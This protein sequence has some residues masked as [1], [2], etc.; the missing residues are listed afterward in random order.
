[1][2]KLFTFILCSVITHLLYSQ[3]YEDCAWIQCQYCK[4]KILKK[5][6]VWNQ[7]CPNRNGDHKWIH[8]GAYDAECNAQS[9][10]SEKEFEAKKEKVKNGQTVISWHTNGKAKL[11][12]S[13]N[14]YY[15]YSDIGVLIEKLENGILSIIENG[16][17]LTG[18]GILKEDWTGLPYFAKDGEWIEDGYK[19]IYKDGR[20]EYDEKDLKEKAEKAKYES[21]LLEIKDCQSLECFQMLKN[22]YPDHTGNNHFKDAE[23]RT[24]LNDI[25]SN[26]SIE[27][28]EKYEKLEATEEYSVKIKN[29]D[30]SLK[31]S[32]M[33]EGNY[34]FNLHS[35]TPYEK[36]VRATLL[37][38]ISQ[39]N[40]PLN[41]NSL[42]GELQYRIILN[43]EKSKITI[44]AGNS[45]LIWYQKD[46]FSTLKD[47][48]GK[49]F[50]LYEG[51]KQICS[52][53]YNDNTSQREIYLDWKTITEL[54][55]DEDIL[56]F[57]RKSQYVNSYFSI[58]FFLGSQLPLLKLKNVEY[59]KF[60][61]NR[62][63]AILLSALKR[64]E[65]D[66][67]N[68][69]FVALKLGYLYWQMEDFD[70]S[71]KYFKM[72]K[73]ENL[74]IEFQKYDRAP[75]YNEPVIAI[76]NLNKW[77]KDVHMVNFTNN[78]IKLPNEEEMIKRIKNL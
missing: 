6:Y 14:N 71:L 40:V 60:L 32:P 73:D 9:L 2:K 30:K 31:T 27:K 64:V 39:N 37:N 11:T 4:S 72:I 70:S 22:K 44:S 62:D 10:K 29:L 17:T 74:P 41:I 65:G 55:T 63:L 69:A 7:S 33:T 67:K 12:K 53:E 8:T 21:M 16:K 20:V 52:C 78:G 13:G 46:K 35:Y 54:K 3:N 28:L 76:S 42:S 18:K 23:R 68:K 24:L 19:K 57:L 34:E 66:G 75:G 38:T 36:A 47:T 59:K 26:P 51:E 5:A 1:M 45:E 61:V 25:I 49:K 58:E 48:K 43:Q 15:S 77:I 50:F 56:C